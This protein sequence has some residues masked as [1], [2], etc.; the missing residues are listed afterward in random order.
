MPSGPLTNSAPALL[1][2]TSSCSVAA[3]LKVSPEA[4]ITFFPCFIKLLAIFP[5]DV[6]FPAP[7]TPTINITAGLLVKSSSGLLSLNISSISSLKAC[8]T[9][10][11]SFKFSFL[12]LV[13]KLLI[14]FSVV[15]IPTSAIINFSSNSSNKFSSTFVK[16]NTCFVFASPCFNLSKKPIFLLSHKLY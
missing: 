5:I 9:C 6:V 7:F 16:L 14:I 8:F 11:A 15:S 3:A 13:L 10:S 4:I 12:I 1:A 2:H